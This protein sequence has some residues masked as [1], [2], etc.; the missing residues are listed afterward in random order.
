MQGDISNA[1]CISRFKTDRNYKKIYC[2]S[3]SKYSTTTMKPSEIQFQIQNIF[4]EQSTE[5]YIEIHEFETQT[6]LF[7]KKIIAHHIFVIWPSQV[8]ILD[9]NMSTQYTGYLSVTIYSM[10]SQLMPHSSPLRATHGMSVVRSNM[11]P[12]LNISVEC[13]ILIWALYRESIALCRLISW[14]RSLT[15]VI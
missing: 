7:D 15:Y 9:P 1:R 2:V 3:Q 12:V 6:G 5:V 14:S 8:K 13:D 4:I 10:Y 11:G